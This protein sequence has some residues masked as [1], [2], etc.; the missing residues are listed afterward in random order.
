MRIQLDKKSIET[1]EGFRMSAMLDLPL[2]VHCFGTSRWYAPF[3]VH[4]E[5]Y[6]AFSIEYVTA[7]T[8]EL[9]ADGERSTL[10]PGDVFLLH[11]GGTHTYRALGNASFRKI[12]MRLSGP[13]AKYLIK[14]HGL[15]N[16]HHV[17][18]CPRMKDMF[19]RMRSFGIRAH[20]TNASGR[21]IADGFSLILHEM[22]LALAARLDTRT[23]SFSSDVVHMKHYL[24][25]M[26]EKDV[27]LADVAAHAGKSAS[28][29]IR[30]FKRETGTTPY[31]YLLG[32]K[33]ELAEYL[34]ANTG[35]SVREVAHETGF[36]DEQYFSRAFRSRTKQRPSDVRKTRG[37]A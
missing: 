18:Q 28:Q 33:M 6:D 9:T 3:S 36:A 29:T 7:G 22:I 23:T 35:L 17:P 4:K 27:R 15:S 20:H 1:I 37:S 26:I 32:R 14:I 11:P 34:L 10:R 5:N 30:K 19:I 2:V 25:S 21:H 13:L 16:V 12:W 31:Q 8:G 24:D